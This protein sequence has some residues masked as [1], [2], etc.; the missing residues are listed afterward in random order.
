MIRADGEASVKV[1][2]IN[3]YEKD[4][5]RNFYRSSRSTVSEILHIEGTTQNNWQM[6]QGE[7]TYTV[8]MRR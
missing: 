6:A 4:S 5:S 8:I 1:S 2:V 3:I 7:T